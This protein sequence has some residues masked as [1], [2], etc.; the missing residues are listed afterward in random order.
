V[1][2]AGGACARAAPGAT[3]ST[4]ERRSDWLIRM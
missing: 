1:V 2:G 3:I 4:H